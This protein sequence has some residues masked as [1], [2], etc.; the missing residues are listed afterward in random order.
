MASAKPDLAG[1]LPAE[2]AVS[3]AA[4]KVLRRFSDPAIVNH[5][6]RSYLW[7]AEHAR[8]GG[9][10]HDADL[11]YVAAL[12]HDLGVAAVFDSLTV[13]FEE[14]GG[15]LAWSLCLGHERF[16]AHAARVE[17]IAVRHMGTAV[18]AADDVEVFLLQFGTSADVSG[19]RVDE[20]PPEFV[21]E[22][23]R[24]YPRLGFD[25]AFVGALEREAARKPGCSADQAVRSGLAARVRDN[26]LPR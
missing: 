4:A 6:M 7:A 24:A 14:V 19:A 8:A 12:A 13:P 11:L 3:G 23:H 10:D 2:N 20:F 1:L 26:G 25:D 9:L 5:S 21:A 16:E 22:L 18:A 17:E 15:A